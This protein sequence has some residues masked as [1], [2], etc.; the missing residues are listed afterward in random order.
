MK[1]MKHIKLSCFI[2]YMFVCI[3][4][5]GADSQLLNC[6]I[7]FEARKDE[8]KAQLDEIDERQQALQVLQNATQVLLD[9]KERQLKNKEQEIERKILLFAQEQEK[10]KTQTEEVH[11][12]NI[13]ELDAKTQHLEQLIAENEAILSQI[14]K[15]KDNKIIQ[16]YK[17]MKE[18]KAASILADMKEEEAV[19]ILSQMEVKDITK[20][21]GKMDNQKAAAITSAIRQVAPNRLPTTD[22]KLQDSQNQNTQNTDE[23]MQDTQE[24]QDMQTSPQEQDFNDEINPTTQEEASVQMS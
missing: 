4:A 19:E 23:N 16:A 2:A 13:A 3:C 17:G 22:N 8:L 7:I 1:G 11:N 24:A 10:A 18:A 6:S 15:V 14:Q 12:K 21:L 9:E 20:I 5:F